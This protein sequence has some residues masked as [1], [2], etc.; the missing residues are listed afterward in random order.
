MTQFKDAE[1]RAKDK[2]LSELVSMLNP[3]DPQKFW[4]IINKSRKDQEK[5]IVQ[6]IRKEDGSYA[7]D[8]DE[9][10]VEMKKNTTAKK[11]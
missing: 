1:L 3:K 11:V 9:I 4:N 2:Y 7:I 5:T 8:D 6:P 10:I